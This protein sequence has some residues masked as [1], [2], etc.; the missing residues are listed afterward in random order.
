MSQG[1]TRELCLRNEK[2][3]QRVVEGRSS[4]SLPSLPFSAAVADSLLSGFVGAWLPGG[5]G[6][7]RLLGGNRAVGARALS[8]TNIMKMRLD[9]PRSAWSLD[10]PR[11]FAPTGTACSLAG[12]RAD[13][14][15]VAR[16][17]RD[18]QP[19]PEKW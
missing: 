18:H 9:I 19:H 2:E 8:K 6:S 3:Q 17:N 7:A 4:E 5:C 15:R 1:Q 16:W 13:S 12:Q 14:Y 11:A 10:R